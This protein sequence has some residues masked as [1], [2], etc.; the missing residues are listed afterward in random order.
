[1]R[2]SVFGLGYVGCVSLGCLAQNGHTVIGVDLNEKKVQNINSGKPTIIEKEIDQIIALQH[3]LGNIS[4]T[5]DALAAVKDT[6]GSGA[7]HKD[8]WLHD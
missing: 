8:P 3:S 7:Y 1:M 4:A 5:H 2:I 6:D